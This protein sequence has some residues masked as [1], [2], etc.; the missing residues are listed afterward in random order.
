MPCPQA[1][2]RVRIAI[3]NSHV[4]ARVDADFR[5]VSCVLRLRFTHPSRFTEIPDMKRIEKA[6]A[7]LLVTVAVTGG[8]SK[9]H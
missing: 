3:V 8:S 2:S 6:L 1:I 5:R 7:S 4:S 9:V